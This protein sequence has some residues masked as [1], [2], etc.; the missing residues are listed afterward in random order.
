MTLIVAVKKEVKNG[1]IP[2]AP[3]NLVDQES[4]KKLQK[5]TK[6]TNLTKM[7]GNC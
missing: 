6:N 1:G 5:I 7:T 4:K 2:R 3:G